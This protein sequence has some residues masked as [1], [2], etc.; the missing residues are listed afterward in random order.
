MDETNFNPWRLRMLAFL[1]EHELLECVRTNVGDVAELKEKAGEKPQEKTARMK[2]LDKRIRKDRHC[3]SQLMAR[4]SD[5]QMD[6]LE[7]D[8]SPKD[9]WDKLHNIHARKSVASRMRIQRQIVTM[10]YDGGKLQQHFLQ[11]EKLIREYRSAGAKLE[12]IDVICHLFISLG[13]AFSG[14]VTALETM[15][16]E[17]LK[18]DFVKNRLLDEETKKGIESPTPSQ[19]DAAFHGAKPLKKQ[20]CFGCNKEGHRVADC[21]EKKK[22]QQ[23]KRKQK[24]KANV[25]DSGSNRKEVCFVSE[26]NPQQA[27][28]RWFIDSGATDHLMQDN[29]LFWELH[30]L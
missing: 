22:P 2:L 17:D 29:E 26:A 20:K 19:S 3:R 4:I 16:Q 25:A 5:A 11:F 14:A 18:L 15:S 1:E 28:T 12:E 27:R 7:E 10:R 21:P 8:M 6:H 24:S 9:I 23:S 13:S 30:R